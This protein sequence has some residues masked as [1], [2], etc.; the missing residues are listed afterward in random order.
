MT[1]AGGCETGERITVAAAGDLLFHKTLQ[2]QAY[3]KGSDFTRF[4]KPLGPLLRSAD[5]LYANLEGPAAGGVALGGRAARRDPGRRL[6]GKVYS[7]HLKSLNFN[8]HPSVVTDLKRVGFD[9]VSTANNHALDRGALGVDRTIDALEE[10]GLPFTGTR[11]QGETNRPWSVVTRAKGFSIAWVACTYSANGI[12]DRKGQLLFCYEQKAQVLREIAEMADRPGID[13]VILT[14]HWGAQNSHR[15]LVRQRTLAREAIDAG[16]IAVIG[17]HPHVLQ[18]WEKRGVADG[19]EGLIVYST[20]NFISNQRRLMERAGV[21]VFVELVRPAGERSRVQVSAAG[22]VP[23]WVVIDNQGHRV[24]LNRG[25]GWAAQALGKTLQLLPPGNRV[26]IE[27]PANLPIRCPRAG[28]GTGLG[29]ANLAKESQ[30]AGS[31]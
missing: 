7:A 19:R 13:A 26:G 30:S 28:P 25:K 1:F 10:A 3:R 23:T 9:V 21:L 29:E 8:Y 15:P 16:A 24:T 31:R 12:P 20:G 2:L 4:F 5:M 22:F 27:W 14:P 11:R 17:T 6:D 18:P